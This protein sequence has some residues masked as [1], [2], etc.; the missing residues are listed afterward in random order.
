MAAKSNNAFLTARI[1]NVPMIHGDQSVLFLSKDNKTPSFRINQNSKFRNK[2]P[3]KLSCSNYFCLYNFEWMVKGISIPCLI[4]WIYSASLRDAGGSANLFGEATLDH[5][6]FCC[7]SDA[8]GCSG[9]E[10]GHIVERALCGS[11]SNKLVW[12]LGVLL[13][14]HECIF[15]CFHH[16]CPLDIHG[17]LIHSHHHHFWYFKPCNTRKVF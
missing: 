3:S 16:S 2:S 8:V 9:L 6:D 1:P 11:H 7:Q 14:N 13:L 17:I 4:K 5:C 15:T 12:L 10:I